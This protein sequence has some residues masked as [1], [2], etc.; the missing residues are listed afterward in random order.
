M[1][2]PSLMFQID[3]GVVAQISAWIVIIFS[4]LLYRFKKVMITLFILLGIVILFQGRSFAMVAVSPYPNSWSGC[5]AY[6][7]CANNSN[8][9]GQAYGY[10]P[11]VYF[12]PQMPYQSMW[13]QQNYYFPHSPSPYQSADCPFCNQMQYYQNQQQPMLFPNYYQH[14]EGGAS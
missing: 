13:P 10:M 8:Y 2:F 12:Y 9:Y 1:V 11:P 4:F 3:Q 7:G 14:P 6:Y 5:N